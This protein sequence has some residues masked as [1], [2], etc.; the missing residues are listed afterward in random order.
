MWRN[1]RP[2]CLLVAALGMGLAPSVLA[3]TSHGYGPY[4]PGYR[5]GYPGPPTGTGS[6]G[7][8]LSPAIDRSG[9]YAGRWPPRY[10]P[11]APAPYGD[12]PPD[13]RSPAP[14]GPGYGSQFYPPWR[15]PDSGGRGFGGPAGFRI[16]R[17]TSDDAYTLTI[18]LDGIGPET[19]Q[20]RTEGHWILLSRMHSVQQTREDSLDDG[21][22]LMRS[23]SHSSGTTNQRLSVPPDAILSAMSREDGADSIRLRIPRRGR[24]GTGNE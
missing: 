5:G 20:I 12:T 15:D 6:C 18:A 3:W 16:S 21:R 22:G 1:I 11:E 8:D 7:P 9:R 13:A 4:G 19:V 17:A 24:Q 23:F 14:A 2:I 10:G